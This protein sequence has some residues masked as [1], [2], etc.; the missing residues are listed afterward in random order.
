M[1]RRVDR[2]SSGL[3]PAGALPA[4]LMVRSKL[5]QAANHHTQQETQT[6]ATV[7]MALKALLQKGSNEDLLR[8][9]SLH[10]C[11]GAKE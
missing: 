2:L 4:A 6:M 9:L 7:K 5:A 3:S 1:Q 8:R 10:R 11:M